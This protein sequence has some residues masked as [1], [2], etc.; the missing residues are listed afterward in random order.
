MI[1]RATCPFCGEVEVRRDQLEIDPAG[2]SFTCSQC[3]ARTSRP[4]E[5]NVLELLAGIGVRPVDGIPAEVFEP[6]S[7]PAFDEDDAV[8]FATLLDG[9][10]WF[11]RLIELIE[12]D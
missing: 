12:V 9:D 8:D 5:R 6:R 10:D 3:D 11:D 1:I 7:G 2:F 4:A